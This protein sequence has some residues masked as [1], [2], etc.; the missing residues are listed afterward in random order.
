MFARLLPGL[1]VLNRLAKLF[2]KDFAF[3]LLGEEV[4]VSFDQVILRP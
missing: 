1:A 3:F 4:G 2:E